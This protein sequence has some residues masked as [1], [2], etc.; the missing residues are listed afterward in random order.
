MTL[1]GFL[2]APA[3]T[4]SASLY[5]EG[6]ETE[7][8]LDATFQAAYVTA[9]LR[10]RH[11]GLEPL[12]RVELDFPAELGPRIEVRTVWDR[13]GELEWQFAWVKEKLPRTLRVALRA[14]LNPGEKFILGVSYGIDT[15]KLPAG[16][17]VSVSPQA[18]R[19][20]TTG[21]YPLPPAPDPRPPN[22]LRLTLRL[23][24]EWQVTSYAKLKR[25]RNG[26]K[27]ATYEVLL[28]PVEAGRLLVEAEAAPDSQGR[29][30]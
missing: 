11:E 6:V 8:Q 1:A 7:V 17:P 30:P 2:A 18:A 28:K 12:D 27:L 29:R 20:S 21:W 16:T 13:R 4:P 9:R 22:A 10:L 5:V 3:V 15:L 23:P 24:K 19:L 26:T 14:P 25:L